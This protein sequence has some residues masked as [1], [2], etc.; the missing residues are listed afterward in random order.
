[1]EDRPATGSSS[2]EVDEAGATSSS[3]SSDARN[4]HR[5]R[6]ALSS[7]KLRQMRSLNPFCEFLNEHRSEMKELCPELT[8]RE[9]VKR[10]AAIWNNWSDNEKAVYRTRVAEERRR[11]VESWGDESLLSCLERKSASPK[12]GRRQ[13]E[14]RQSHE[15]ETGV[16]EAASKR[17]PRKRP[18][19][20]V[21]DSSNH[22]GPGYYRLPPSLAQCSEQANWAQV[23]SC[24]VKTKC[25]K[26]RQ[27]A[28]S[29]GRSSAT[30]ANSS[31][32]AQE[33]SGRPGSVKAL[34]KAARA[35]MAQQGEPQFS[36]VEDD[37]YLWDYQACLEG[38]NADFNTEARSDAWSALDSDFASASQHGSLKECFLHNFIGFDKKLEDEC[39]KL[40]LRDNNLHKQLKAATQELAVKKAQDDEERLALNKEDQEVCDALLWTDFIYRITIVNALKYVRVPGFPSAVNPENVVQ[41]LRRAAEFIK[42]NGQ[43]NKR[44][45]RRFKAIMAELTMPKDPF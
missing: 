42:Q 6:G 15:S 4:R 7:E 11:I 33:S 5:Y 8:A 20:E 1:M 25:R 21:G 24:Q 17:S 3:K 26:T 9:V 28:D 31:T 29:S 23:G 18:T 16:K 44:F 12:K 27:S 39:H 37:Q 45:I 43:S 34:L 14:I 38:A 2:G 19:H 35:K 10:A 41:F 13:E 30:S 36:Q 40:M 32:L 22:E